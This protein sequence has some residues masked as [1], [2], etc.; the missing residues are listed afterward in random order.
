[1][2][3]TVT[4]HDG[5]AGEHG[6]ARH[7]RGG[8]ATGSTEARLWVAGSRPVPARMPNFCRGTEPPR[9]AK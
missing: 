7:W 9:A 8:A 3:R 2:S 5:T 1:M 4:G 6:Q